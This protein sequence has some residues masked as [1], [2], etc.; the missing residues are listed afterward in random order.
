M[1]KESELNTFYLNTYIKW[2]M[3]KK[4]AF[5]KI[6]DNEIIRSDIARELKCSVFNPYLGEVIQSLITLN[7]IEYVK[8]MGNMKILKINQKKI[9]EILRK[10]KYFKEF[11]EVVRVSNLLYNI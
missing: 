1:D 3:A 2:N 5:L 6:K 7:A 10:T 9:I 4:I 8:T 11:E